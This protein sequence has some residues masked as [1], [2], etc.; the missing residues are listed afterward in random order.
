MGEFQIT[1]I[2][3]VIFVGLLFGFGIIE[4]LLPRRTLKP[5]KTKRWITNLLI[6]FIDSMLVKLLFKSAAIGVAVWAE[7]NGYGLFN[8][9]EAPY[10]LAFGLSF[11][12]LDFSIWLT[13]VVSHKIPILWKIHRMH[14]S[15]VDIDASTGIRFHPFEIVLSMCWKFL[16]VL[17]LGAPVLSVLI[18]EVVL[19]GGALFNHSN[20]K[21]PLKIDRILRWI[22]VTPDMHRV[23]HSVISRE[24]NSNYGFNLSIWDK[25]FS[26]YVDQP[27]KGHRE[28][29]IGLPDWQDEKP[30]RLDWTLMV[31]FKK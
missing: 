11:A 7:V 31:P 24:Y 15:D 23:H 5:I 12:V 14:H 20:I 16:V 27:E 3:P 25:I 21:I 22:I 13:H 10:W 4:F 9:I 28:M 1:D 29:T 26:T 2:R 6:I 17:A 30:A 18:F 8:V 19:N